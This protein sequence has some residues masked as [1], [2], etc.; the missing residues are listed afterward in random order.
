MLRVYRGGSATPD[1]PR[2]VWG[3]V[4]L[5]RGGDTSL[6]L[7]GGSQRKAVGWGGSGRTGARRLFQKAV[8][9]RVQ[10]AHLPE[11]RWAVPLEL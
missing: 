4:M 5:C 1:C 8:S 11:S 10:R 7:K 9:G 6:S 3:P 2:K